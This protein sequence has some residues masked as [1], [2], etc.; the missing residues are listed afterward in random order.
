MPKKSKIETN[1]RITVAAGLFVTHTRDAQEIADMLDTTERNV[2]RWSKSDLWQDTLETLNYEG[3][4]NFRINQTDVNER[5]EDKRLR[6]IIGSG[7]NIINWDQVIE[8][9]MESNRDESTTSDEYSIYAY[10][11]SGHRPIIYSGSLS[12]CIIIMAEL[13]S[14][15][16][17][18]NSTRI[19]DISDFRRTSDYRERVATLED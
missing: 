8:I 3:G 19:F 15:I 18:S 12:S 1:I 2:Y 9:E 11:Q 14:E 16:A 17:D 4:Q 13:R 5:P 10:G 7:G 6:A